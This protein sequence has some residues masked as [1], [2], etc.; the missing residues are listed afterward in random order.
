MFFN[1]LARSILKR[2]LL[3]GIGLCA[4]VL[5]VTAGLSRLVIDFKLS[6]FFSSKSKMV[7][8][9]EEHKNYWGPD[10]N[11]VV[12]VTSVQEG[13]LLEP[14]RLKR[15]ESV[16]KELKRAPAIDRVTSLT[17]I[18]HMHEVGENELI[19][20][21]VLKSMPEKADSPAWQRWADQ[22]LDD[23]RLVP[24]IL[25]PNGRTS[26]ILV[27]FA[28]ST[29]D[30]SIILPIVEGIRQTIAPHQGA[31][32]LKFTSAGVPVIRADLISAT[33]R[34]QAT[35]LPV[36]MLAISILLFIIFGN[37]HGVL[38]PGVAATI[39]VMMTFGMMGYLGE[40]IGVV[41]QT[42]TLLLPTIAIADAIHL[43][44]RFH[45]EAHKLAS[46]G[47]LLTREQ[48]YQVITTTLQHLGL[49]CLLTSFT[50]AVG[51]ASLYFAEMTVL[52]HFGLFAGLGIVFSYGSV[53]IIVPLLLS[54]TR[55]K[56][57]TNAENGKRLSSGPI[58]RYLTHAGEFATSRPKLVLLLTL[59]VAL[60]F[61]HASGRVIVDNN[62]SQ[63]LHEAHP[64][65]QANMLVDN[66]LGGLI[67]LDVA[68]SADTPVLKD[69]ALLK[70]ILRASEELKTIPG[71]KLIQSPAHFIQSAAEIILGE[72]RIPDTPEG[73]AQLYL[74]LEGHG[75]M[76]RI[77]DSSHQKGRILV[78][79]ADE[80]ANKFMK[81]ER[82]VGQIIAKH[83][84]PFP[85][86]KEVT[87]LGVIAYRG[88]NNVARGLRTSL[89]VA[90]LFVTLII[91]LVFR[92]PII[93]L[94]SLIP[95]T[96]PLLIAYGFLGLSGFALEPTVALIFTVGFGIAV[97]DTIH[98]LARYK[99]GLRAGTPHRE[100]IHQAVQSSGHAVLVTSVILSLGLGANILSD[101][102]TIKMMGICGVTI[103]LTA[104]ACDLYVLPA[105]LMLNARRG[106]SRTP[107]P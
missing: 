91:A 60:F 80:G 7:D 18:T 103:M 48:K 20:E 107:S 71:V 62:L 85:I 99:E 96:L 70:A 21:P 82:R 72:G 24:N 87:G 84:D 89:V 63:I 3:Y 92:S 10:D 11:T 32:G 100:A 4:L 27:E 79:M 69:P 5:G 1:H 59:F 41:N 26:A 64:T 50:T 83:L 23:E 47:A 90:F 16:T 97:D 40:P 61:T 17:N 51:F 44:S 43:V 45:E 38:I 6:N 73:V 67:G 31:L 54:F 28:G 49:A 33:L 94:L 78:N 74:L 8:R 13:S 29:D 68:I 66:D 22:I 98:L 56:V 55:G 36:A 88:V 39:P 57:T 12:I 53:L 75:E 101:F 42:L 58:A 76:D 52:R 37:L 102:E 86:E 95:N 2:R 106:E 25:A 46:P 35:T 14:E 34:D 15:L 65:S 30:V 19:V 81:T 105:L 93:A 77:L 9:Y 104:L